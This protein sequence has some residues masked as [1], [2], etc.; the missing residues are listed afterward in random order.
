MGKSEEPGRI[1]TGALQKLCLP[2]AG[3]AE[4]WGGRGGEGCGEHGVGGG[5]RLRT[6]KAPRPWPC[7]VRAKQLRAGL[8]RASSST[9][10]FVPKSCWLFSA[11]GSRKHRALGRYSRACILKA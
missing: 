7:S 1:W 5:G 3:L 10:S 6:T 8:P 2:L 4:H 11:G 9:A